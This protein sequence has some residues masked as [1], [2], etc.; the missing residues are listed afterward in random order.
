MTT[1]TARRALQRWSKRESVPHWQI[2]TTGLNA[3]NVQPSLPEG[4]VLA[5]E[6]IASIAAEAYFLE[7]V[8]LVTKDGAEILLP[9][10]PTTAEKLEAML[11]R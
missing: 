1:E 5:F 11:A 7:D 9:G 2:R 8:Y 3:G 10:L 6:P 4:M